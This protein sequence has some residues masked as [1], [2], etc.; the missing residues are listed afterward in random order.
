[1]HAPSGWAAVVPLKQPASAKQ[2]LVGLD[3]WRPALAVAFATDVVTALLASRGVRE[4]VVVG[5]DGLAPALLDLPA[6]HRIADVRGLNHA[7]EAGIACGRR[8]TATGV[9]VVPAD[10]PCLRPAD[11][12]V[13]LDGAQPHRAQVLADADGLGTSALVIPADVTFVPR[14]G[15]GSYALHLAA[16]AMPLEGDLP[17]ARRDVDT[18]EHLETA[19]RLG[20]GVATA[21]V[22]AQLD[23]VTGALPAASS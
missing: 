17:T 15:P 9:L 14:F 2:R 1:V 8:L 22:L 3:A 23:A 4:I 7:V 11:V 5:G 10:V 18:V 12:D 16:G 13:L 19:R 21:R 20:V 6:V